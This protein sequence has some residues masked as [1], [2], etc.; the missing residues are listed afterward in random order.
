VRHIVDVGQRTRDENIALAGNRHARRARLPHGVEAVGVAH[1][2]RKQSRA[3]GMAEGSSKV[4]QH[5]NKGAETQ[6]DA[7][8]PEVYELG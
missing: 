7:K 2:W 8:A 5:G 4:V 6:G 3:V 1:G